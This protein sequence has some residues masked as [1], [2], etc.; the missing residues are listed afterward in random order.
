MPLSVCYFL[1]HLDDLT[2]ALIRLV[3]TMV[4]QLVSALELRAVLMGL[5]PGSHL[6]LKLLV[7]SAAM[8]HFAERNNSNPDLQC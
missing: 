8:R 3:V 4:L 2:P 7:Q 1:A 5:F 6:P